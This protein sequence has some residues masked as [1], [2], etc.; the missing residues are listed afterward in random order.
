MKLSTDDQTKRQL[1]TLG[2]NQNLLERYFEEEN[3]RENRSN[4]RLTEIDEMIK[5]VNNETDS[6]FQI[7][8]EQRAWM[9]KELANIKERVEERRAK[10]EALRGDDTRES[11]LKEFLL[12]PKLVF[13]TTSAFTTILTILVSMK[14]NLVPFAKPIGIVTQVPI[15]TALDRLKH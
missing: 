10:L 5:S 13:A 7:N 9:K 15:V 11:S 8:H 6:E 1:H 4:T 14:L 3:R 2:E 12:S